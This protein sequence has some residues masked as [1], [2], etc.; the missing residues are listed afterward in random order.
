MGEKSRGVFLHAAYMTALGDPVTAILCSQI[1]YWYSLSK[2]GRSKL[3]IQKKGNHWIAKSAKEWTEETGLTPAQVKRAIGVL[4]DRGV[5]EKMV[6]LFNGAPTVHV[7]ALQVQGKSLKEGE[8]LFAIKGVGSPPSQ[9]A[10]PLAVIGDSV[11]IQ[12]LPLAT[13]AKSITETLQE[14]SKETTQDSM[15]SSDAV[16]PKEEIPKQ[17]PE[18]N[19]YDVVAGML[20]SESKTAVVNSSAPTTDTSPILVWNQLTALH[21]KDYGEYLAPNK[22]ELGQ[23]TQFSKDLGSRAVPVLRLLFSEWGRFAK[24]AKNKHGAYSIPV[25]PTLGFML[26]Y[27]NAALNYW[28]QEG[29]SAICESTEYSQSEVYQPA[30]S[31]PLAGGDELPA[32]SLPVGTHQPAMNSEK[33]SGVV[34]NDEDRLVT[35]EEIQARRA[36]TAKKT[37]GSLLPSVIAVPVAIVS[38][39][40]NAN[41]GVL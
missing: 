4:V 37:Q 25:M 27:P 2:V 11:A 38:P 14:N 15:A 8:Y 3:R 29:K 23:L 32:K 31:E 24:Y 26:R 16:L 21:A 39:E 13:H 30:S 12:H 17:Q 19:E 35:L 41:E 5:I 10:N 22:K 7:R 1:H 36:L 20:V 40:S 34:D 28:Q 6:T 9:E 18:K 33:S